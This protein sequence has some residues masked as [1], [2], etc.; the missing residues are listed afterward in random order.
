MSDTHETHPTTSSETTIS[1]RSM[2]RSA[3]VLT[4]GGGALLAF[5]LAARNGTTAATFAEG[6]PSPQGSPV[7]CASPVA[8]S[9]VV[10]PLTVVTVPM[11]NQ[12]RFEPEH[13]V[14]KLG[15]TVRWDNISNMPHT[16]TDDPEQNPVAKSHPDY[17]LLPESAEPWGSPLL[18]PG[19]SWEY[20]FTAAGEYRYFCI[21]HVLSGMRGSITV[22]C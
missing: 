7:A 2:L 19:E 20:T 14:I 15:E 3:G 17:V 16:A 9:P 10:S 21:P 1:R 6:T 11:T 12:L 4:A 5:A 8:A 13:L 18:Q 22:E